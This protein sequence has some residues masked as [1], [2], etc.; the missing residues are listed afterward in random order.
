MAVG[1]LAGHLNG[2]R[3]RLRPKSIVAMYKLFF[4]E[5][6]LEASV[7]SIIDQVDWVVLA[8]SDRAWSDAPIEGDDLTQVI[9]RLKSRFGSK[10]LPFTGSWAS[11]LQ[12]VSDALDWIRRNLPKTTHVLYIDSDEVYTS[13]QAARLVGY[14][15]DVRY[16]TRALA[17]SLHTY[18]RT[19][20]YRIDPP[21]P[22]TPLALFPVFPG[23][24]F[25]TFRRVNIRQ[26]HVPVWMHHFSYVRR[27]DERIRAKLEAF[28]DDEALIPGWYENVW[29]KWTPETKDFHPTRPEAY[30]S[31]VPVLPEE[32]PPSVVEAYRRWHT[33]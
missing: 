27:S 33:T 30:H 12:H 5:E 23:T 15:H 16:T 18:F 19:I 20:Y 9:E 4:G 17:V 14:A 7:E 1:R 6:W 31:V 32:L 3:F 2:L 8:V 28:K 24:R 26:M 10:I 25:T 29:L 21:E 22:I 13:E 11:Q